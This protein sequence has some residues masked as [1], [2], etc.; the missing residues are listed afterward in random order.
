[1]IPAFTL[2]ASL[3]ISG[4]APPPDDLPP[5]RELAPGVHALS[6]S[7]RYGSANAG[8]VA[9]ADH[10]LLIGAPHPD[11]A[12]RCWSEAVRTSGKPVRAAVLTHLRRGEI[13]AA[14]F[15][16]RKG[17]ILVAQEEAAALL[18]SALGRDGAVTGGLPATRIESFTDRWE[19][20]DAA[21]HLRVVSL[22]HAAGP[23]DAAA[24]VEG[25][26]VLFTGEV[27]SHGPRAALPGGD[28]ERWIR[29]LE[30]TRKL[31]ART[32]VPGFGS[33]G[34]SEILVRQERF[35]REVRRQVA[36]LISQGKTL[37]DVQAQVRIEPE[38]LVW[39]PYDQ[40]QKED[41]D[42]LHRELT[43][44]AAPFGV[45]AA[46]LSGPR[47]RAL[48]L[49]ADRFHEPEHLESGLKPVF[50]GAGVHAW[51]AFDV[52]ALNR[53]NLK[54]VDLLV[55]L[56][57]GALWPEGPEK[58]MVVWMTPEQEQAVADFVE[59]GGGFL[60]LHNSTGLY[61]EGGPYRR[62]I[63][64]AYQGHG[65]LE[66]FRVKVTD[67]RHPITRG[68]SE[69]QVADEQ[70]TPAPDRETVRLFL[71]SRSDEG[72]LGAAGWTCEAGRGRVA[73]LA[74]GHTREALLHP[75]VQ[76]LMRNAVRW[77]LK[78]EDGPPGPGGG[79]R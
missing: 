8:W 41:L 13:E 73:Y 39:M 60:A 30:E 59:A 79:K 19:F 48:A 15:L 77:C 53:E 16:A 43:V 21:Q 2:L 1:M 61:P 45:P 29:A 11:L 76:L 54:A 68:V 5:S 31:G 33:T 35:L 28:T 69:Y 17:V 26:G 34:G 36:Y 32:V 18:R 55:M 44:P 27:C 3:F 12:E 42:H 23:G 70:H 75:M 20:R 50:E 37:E 9:F 74:N 38:W 64:G 46:G 67:P 72:V 71:E 4:A 49:I 56:R 25:A 22:G 66:R 65:P 62:L 47:P 24:F 57:D 6:S 78:L 40:P 51:F 7:N 63:G 10:V 52:R 14:R 58:P